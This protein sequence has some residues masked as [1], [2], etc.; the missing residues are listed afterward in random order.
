MQDAENVEHGR[1]GS[2]TFPG[3]SRTINMLVIVVVLI[4]FGSVINAVLKNNADAWSV[5]VIIVIGGGILGYRLR[6]RPPRLTITSEGMEVV[7]LHDARQFG[8]ADIEGQFELASLEGGTAVCFALTKEFKQR[9][10]FG[11]HMLNGRFDYSI[12]DSYAVSPAEL[13]RV[14]NRRL[15]EWRRLRD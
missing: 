14:L 7:Q 11:L 3:K 4:F 13:E 2:V 8:F 15:S 5:V 1:N 9:T 12:G 6:T 10:R